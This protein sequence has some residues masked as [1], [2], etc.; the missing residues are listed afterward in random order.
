MAIRKIALTVGIV[1]ALMPAVALAQTGVCET[2]TIITPSLWVPV[3]ETIPFAGINERLISVTAAIDST[4]IS[5]TDWINNQITLTA[6]T[7]DTAWYSIPIKYVQMLYF[8]PIF[9][10]LI[11]FLIG[12]LLF[13][14]F[15]MFAMF[16]V[17]NIDF[18]MKIIHRAMEFIRWIIDFILQLIDILIPLSV[19][20]I[21]SVGIA[22]SVRAQSPTPTSPDPA[23]SMPLL[24]TPSMP[25]SAS[26]ELDDWFN[27]SCTEITEEAKGWLITLNMWH[28]LDAVLGFGLAA[29]AY[30]YIERRVSPWSAGEDEE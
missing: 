11:P 5:A 25:I 22:R 24:P 17:D 8:F 21:L 19:A 30:F 10:V 16:V 27:V 13:R 26:G 23:S 14:I 20:I 12:V 9:Q 6:P 1:I 4:H 28:L 29:G 2:C 18:A 3:T 7:M 15:V